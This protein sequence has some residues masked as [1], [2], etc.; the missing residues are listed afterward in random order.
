MT[1]EEA[2]RETA[3]TRDERGLPTLQM[4]VNRKNLRGRIR[5]I[6]QNINA[7]GTLSLIAKKRMKIGSIIQEKPD[8]IFL[9]DL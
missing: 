4:P 3:Q 2:W 6:S 5:F 7:F 1:M 8:V 9:Q